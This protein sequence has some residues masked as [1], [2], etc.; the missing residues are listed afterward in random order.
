MDTANIKKIGK[1]M[2]AFNNV[3]FVARGLNYPVALE[4]ALKLKE[5]AYIHAEGYAAGELKHG[6]F[7]LLDAERRWWRLPLMTQLTKLC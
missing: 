7:A 2:A 4:G 3:L 1:Y 5:T 6:S